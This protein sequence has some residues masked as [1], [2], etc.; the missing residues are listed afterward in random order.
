MFI[1]K[2]CDAVFRRDSCERRSCEELRR[3][4]DESDKMLLQPLLW[5]KSYSH[6]WYYLFS[7][8]LLLP[9]PLLW[10]LL[11]KWLLFNYWVWLI[12]HEPFYCYYF[13]HWHLLLL[14]VLA[15]NDDVG[16]IPTTIYFAWSFFVARTINDW[17]KAV[18]VDDL[19]WD[20]IVIDAIAVSKVIFVDWPI[21][22]CL[23]HGGNYYICCGA[24]YL[25]I[26]LF[27]FII[28]FLDATVKHYWHRRCCNVVGLGYYLWYYWKWE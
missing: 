13:H 23:Y 20:N 2:S 22:A 3:C 15:I 8:F 12:S 5:E 11:L 17:H 24:I 14:S 21:D 19:L 4:G 28:F 10:K 26:F 27:I 25:F 18:G 16:P 1:E 6:F 7:F 9:L